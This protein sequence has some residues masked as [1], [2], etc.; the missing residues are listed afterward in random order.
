[1]IVAKLANLARGSGPDR[2]GAIREL[3]S[4]AKGETS[5]QE[6]LC[7]TVQVAARDTL[8]ELGAEAKVY[9][10]DLERSREW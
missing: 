6:S 9:L 8:R 1:M 7:G 10:D 2:A 3:Y 4:L 5:Q